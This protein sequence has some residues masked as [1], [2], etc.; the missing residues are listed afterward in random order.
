MKIGR[1]AIAGVEV[2]EHPRKKSPTP[3]AAMVPNGRAGPRKTQMR[4]GFMMNLWVNGN[5]RRPFLDVP[6]F[7]DRRQVP[8]MW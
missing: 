6:H 5:K 7:T 1:T 8:R 3:K 2:V 4:N